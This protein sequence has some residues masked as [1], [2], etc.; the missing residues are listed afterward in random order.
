MVKPVKYILQIIGAKKEITK[1][2]IAESATKI[3]VAFSNFAM[4]TEKIPPKIV[5]KSDIA[6]INTQDVRNTLRALSSL[7]LPKLLPIKLIAPVQTIKEI[8]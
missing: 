1:I 4:F 3:S 2:Y 8:A 5:T 7:P 6:V